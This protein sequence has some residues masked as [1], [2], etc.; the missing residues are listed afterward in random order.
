MQSRI[1]LFSLS[2]IA[3][4]ALAA[5]GCFNK[6]EESVAASL[7]GDASAESVT[8][9][10]VGGTA[11]ETPA[12]PQPFT[13]AEG[14]QLMDYRVNKGDSLWD[15]AQRFQTKVS[16][17]Q[18]A[19]AM[20]GDSIIE[21]QKIKIPTRLTEMPAAVA[22]PK[23]TP[24]VPPAPVAR[25]S[26]ASRTTRRSRRRASPPARVRPPGLA[27]PV[28]ERAD[29]LTMAAPSWPAWPETTVLPAARGD[30]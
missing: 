22:A 25:A 30:R 2:A 7:S 13:L 19:N 5:T 11:A 4:V 16:R 15:L 6:K 12:A 23:P 18:S 10:M 8:A 1:T 17:I 14:E 3:A 27:A 20:T 29:R 26:C 21:G 28:C 9:E 24:V